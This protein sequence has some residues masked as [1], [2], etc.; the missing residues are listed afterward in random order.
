[1]SPGPT[2][3]LF[4]P[5]LANRARRG[6]RLALAITTVA[7][8]AAVLGVWSVAGRSTSSAGAASTAVTGAVRT[9]VAAHSAQLAVTMRV[10]IPGSGVVDATGNGAV[11][12]RTDASRV[13]FTFR[14]PG[15]LAG[16]HLAEVFVGN[17]I[18]LSLPKLDGA[19]A[20][21]PW[22]SQSLAPGA[23]IAPGNS[24]P[25]AALGMLGSPQNR[26]VPVGVSTIDGSAVHG[27]QVT[28][29]P[30]SLRAGLA[31]A[32]LPTGLRKAAEQAVGARP[33]VITVDVN[34]TTGTVRRL[35]TDVA[36]SLGS[37]PVVAAVTED[38]GGY[39]TRVAVTPPPP[40]QVL[41]LTQLQAAVKSTT[42]TL[43]T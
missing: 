3:D 15:A 6:R 1:V 18:F 40:G 9:T 10:R 20:G 33:D 27:Y 25:V 8:V 26:V 7:V 37:H 4:P 5:R 42:S 19:V 30:G 21:K 17:T 31:H 41:T 39:G 12:L 13:A 38:F 16:Q 36:L 43:S 14:G 29:S 34:D 2:A 11:D 24:D 28:V 32:G 23:V 22:V 35:V